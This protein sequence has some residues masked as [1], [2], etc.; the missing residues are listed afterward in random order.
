M[1]KGRREKTYLYTNMLYL[2]SL[3]SLLYLNE[4]LLYSRRGGV[5]VVEV[6]KLPS[7]SFRIY[8]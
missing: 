3:S 8:N 1:R 4:V 6:T 2:K 5:H 7:V